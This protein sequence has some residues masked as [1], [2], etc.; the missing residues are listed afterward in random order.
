MDGRCPLVT[1]CMHI[2]RG[3]FNVDAAPYNCPNTV[4]VALRFIWSCIRPQQPGGTVPSSDVENIWQTA[5]QPG[6]HCHQV[7]WV[8]VKT[9]QQQI[10]I[11]KCPLQSS[12]DYVYTDEDCARTSVIVSW[13]TFSHNLWPQMFCYKSTNSYKTCLFQWQRQRL[14]DYVLSAGVAIL[15]FKILLKSASLARDL[16][17]PPPDYPWETV[18]THWI[19]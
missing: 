7:N 19:I 14:F 18:E 13:L 8:P 11:I 9:Y 5:H 1:S 4:S 12:S 16:L 17:A 2:I 15:N 10:S 3:L 6:P